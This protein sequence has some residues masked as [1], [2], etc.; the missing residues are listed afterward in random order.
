[1][2]HPLL[3]RM[4]LGGAGLAGCIAL[5]SGVARAAES[6]DF[7]Q[8]PIIVN[9]AVRAIAPSL[10]GTVTLPIRPNRYLDDWERARRDDS[11]VPP[12]RI[13]LRRLAGCRRDSRFSTSRRP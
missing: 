12:M 7:G 11:N 4:L 10:F 13:W 8:R 3:V 5:L 2:R 9:G 1:M 6:A